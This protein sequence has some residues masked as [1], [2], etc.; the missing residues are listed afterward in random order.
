MEDF[1]VSLYCS[2]LEGSVSQATMLTY[3]KILDLVKVW[4]V[5]LEI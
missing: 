3:G 4:E 1:T 2:N 5:L